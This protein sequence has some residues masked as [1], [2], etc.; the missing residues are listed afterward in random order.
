MA[1]VVF[2]DG[3][4]NQVRSDRPVGCEVYVTA[5]CQFAAW[6]QK[7]PEQRVHDAAAVAGEQLQLSAELLRIERHLYV[8]DRGGGHSIGPPGA[9]G[10]AVGGPLRALGDALPELRVGLGAVSY[11][12]LTLPTI[13]LV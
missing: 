13:L 9:V 10:G 4:T 12:H 11:T 7:T 8:S 1:D 2:P 6:A 3:T 5:A